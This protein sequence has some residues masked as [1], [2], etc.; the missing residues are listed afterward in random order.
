MFYPNTTQAPALYIPRHAAGR[1]WPL[2]ARFVRAVHAVDRWADKPMSGAACLAC[3][4][5]MG[6]LFG[7]LVFFCYFG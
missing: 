5:L 7:P 4:A 6:L 3:G 1:F 2:L